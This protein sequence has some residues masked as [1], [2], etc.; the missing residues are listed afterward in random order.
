MGVATAGAPPTARVSDLLLESFDYV[1]DR[2]RRR[3]DGLLQEEYLWEPV[4]GSWSIRETD[5][6]WRV[7]RTSPEPSPA[8][9]TTIA[10][11]LW[12][13]GSE[14]LAGYTSRGLGD[15]VLDVQDDEWYPDVDD[16][17]AALDRAWAAF[18]EGIA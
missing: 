15:W 11:R 10:W 2:V 7:E 4:E 8:P 1:W 13:I 6:V 14:C 17:L 3:M 18:R 5:G 12:H 16:A 9:V